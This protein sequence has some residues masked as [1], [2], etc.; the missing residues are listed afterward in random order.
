LSNQSRVDNRPPSTSTPHCP[1][2]WARRWYG[3]RLYKCA[4]PVR[5]ACWLPWGWWKP[6][7]MKSYRSMAL[8]AWSSRV[9]VTGIKCYSQ[10]YIM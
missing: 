1:T 4:S 2:C 10:A 5:N 9:L 7:I 3:T 8:C 6:C